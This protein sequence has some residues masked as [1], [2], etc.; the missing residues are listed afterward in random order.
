MSPKKEPFVVVSGYG[1][2][3]VSMPPADLPPS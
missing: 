1:R 2:V 3:L